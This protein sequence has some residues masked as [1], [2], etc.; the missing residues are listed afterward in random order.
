M[1]L[2]WKILS[3]PKTPRGSKGSANSKKSG[4]KVG[5]TNTTRVHNAKLTENSGIDGK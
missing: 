4:K 1:A 3:P 2:G 5:G